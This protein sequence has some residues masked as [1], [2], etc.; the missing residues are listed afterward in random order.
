MTNKRV[1]LFL[2]ANKK[3]SH[4][5]SPN[6]WS[7]KCLRREGKVCDCLETKEVLPRDK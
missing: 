5:D 6:P 7:N 4:P 1:C 3:C 2:Q